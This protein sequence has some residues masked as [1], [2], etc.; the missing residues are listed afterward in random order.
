MSCMSLA[1]LLLNILASWPATYS[2]SQGLLAIRF[3]TEIGSTTW[4]SGRGRGLPAGGT[5][6][7]R[8]V[9]GSSTDSR[10]GFL[11]FSRS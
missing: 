1:V 5:A 6:E 11:P 4:V 7:A 10:F 8:G 3:N 9:V 2:R